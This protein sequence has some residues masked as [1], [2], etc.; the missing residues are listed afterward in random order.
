MHEVQ[1]RL[2]RMKLA[3]IRRAGNG[4]LTILPPATMFAR[5]VEHLY[6]QEPTTSTTS[7]ATTSRLKH[8]NSKRRRT[9]HVNGA[10][11]IQDGSRRTRAQSA[12]TGAPSWTQWIEMQPVAFAIPLLSSFRPSPS[13]PPSLSCDVQRCNVTSAA[14]HRYG[15]VGSWFATRLPIASRERREYQARA[16][17]SDP[18][19][20]GPRT[21]VTSLSRRG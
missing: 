14:R 12:S 5:F 10:R 1:R 18:A 11:S 16:E 20:C 2:T 17:G 21:N 9:R 19:W 7:R 4:R 15:H 6:S 13:Q 8:A 3:E